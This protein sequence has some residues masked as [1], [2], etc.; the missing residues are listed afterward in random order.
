MKRMKT[1][2]IILLVAISLVSC[3]NNTE[4]Q[5]VTLKNKE[6]KNTTTTSLLKMGCYAY[7]NNNNT[8]TFEIINLDHGITGKLTYALD[9]KDSNSGTFNGKLHNNKLFGTYTF[10]SEGIES[11]RDVAF[12]VENN[13]LIEGY[14]ELN[15]EGTAFVDKNNIKYTSIMPLT[16]VN[17]V[18]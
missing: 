2:I 5:Q 15:K 11:K 9:G 12:L 3:K 17:C 13:Q 7:N 6:A 10:L 16:K 4:K 1:S 8:I 14:G 18:K